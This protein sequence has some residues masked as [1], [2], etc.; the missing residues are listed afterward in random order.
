MGGAG[1]GNSVVAA[2]PAL[3]PSAEWYPTH[4]AKARHGWGTQLDEEGRLVH[5]TTLR[6]AAGGCIPAFG[7]VVGM[8]IGV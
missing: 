8:R 3:L 5:S 6:T 7:R 2:A 1:E 4:A